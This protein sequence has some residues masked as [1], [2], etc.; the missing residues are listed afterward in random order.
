MNIQNIKAIGTKSEESD[1]YP[2]V[3]AQNGHLW[4]VIECRN[5]IQWI[6]QL[7]GG[8]NHGRARWRN[9]SYCRTKR[10]LIELL[11]SYTAEIDPNQ[12]AV[13]VALPDRIG[14]AA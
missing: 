6:I 13:L 2:H 12:L 11:R 3:V 14:G 9:R 10:T 7:N 1:D 5:A 4:R 8:K